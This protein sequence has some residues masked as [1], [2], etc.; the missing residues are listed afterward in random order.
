MIKIGE[1]Q[2]LTINREMPQGFYLI[3][4]EDNEVLFPRKYITDEMDIDDEI[5]VFVYCDSSDL[6]V[7]T[8]ET[9]VFTVGQFAALHVFDVSEHGAFCD[10]GVNK[11]LFIPFRNQA[12]KL[13]PKTTHIVY[14]YLDEL[15]ERL[16]GT[17]KLNG[18]LESTSDGNLKTGQKVSLLVSAIT[19]LG[20]KAIIDQMYVGMIYKNETHRLLNIGEQLDGYIKP[21][22][23]DGK[24][25]ISID[26]IGHQNIEPNAQMILEKLD[27]GGG[28]LPFTDKSDPE[29]IRKTFG[30]SKKLFKKAIGALYKQKIIKLEKEGIYKND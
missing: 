14:M 20:Y 17:T 7:A 23:P 26:S 6:E 25:D 29:H 12:Y 21:I 1:Y 22:R 4:D 2:V 15:T 18:I 24:I 27:K 19:D 13:K 3:D 8:T 30:I 9:P 11:Q 10:W 5:K 28:F 16:V